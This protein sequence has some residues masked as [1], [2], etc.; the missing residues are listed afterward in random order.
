MSD[1]LEQVAVERA[2]ADGSETVVRYGVGVV[3]F[4]ERFNGYVVRYE[5]E[6]V[7]QLLDLIKQLDEKRKAD[8]AARKA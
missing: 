7:P 4:E 8:R 5:A 6:N 3:A 1:E 2:A